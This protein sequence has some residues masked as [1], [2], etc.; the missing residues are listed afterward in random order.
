MPELPLENPLEIPLEIQRSRAA[1]VECHARA[2]ALASLPAMSNVHACRVA[3]DELLL[4]APPALA[5]EVRRR[6]E[7]HLAGTDR[8]ALVLDQSDGWVIFSLPG[9]AGLRALRMLAVF[10]LPETRPAFLQGAVAGGSAKLLLLPG[11]VHLLVPYPLRDHLE[12]RLRDVAGPAVRIATE[13]SP[14]AGF[15]AAG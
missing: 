2:E 15:A 14:F 11:V 10:P 13:E 3:P 4:L 12:R 8:G 1:V 7:A 5:D 9:E 6:A